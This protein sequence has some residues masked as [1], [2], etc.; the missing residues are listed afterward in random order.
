MQIVTNDP[1]LIFIQWQLNVEKIRAQTYL[2]AGACLNP[3][4][5]S[6]TLNAGINELTYSLREISERSPN[7]QHYIALNFC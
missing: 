3:V 1:L 6:I 5:R 4:A 2:K 7:H